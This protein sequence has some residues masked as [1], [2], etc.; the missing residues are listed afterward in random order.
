M[1]LNI[2]MELLGYPIFKTMQNSQPASQPN[3]H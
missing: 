2:T 3:P 1:N